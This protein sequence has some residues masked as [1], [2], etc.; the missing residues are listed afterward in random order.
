M[1]NF[2]ELM[3][4]RQ[5][6]G[7]S[8]WVEATFLGGVVLIVAFRRHQIVSLYMFRVSVI[9]FGLSIALPVLLLPLTH[10]VVG[11]S[12]SRSPP[13]LSDAAYMVIIYGSGPI[14]F[15][16]SVILCVLS[17]LPARS[18]YPAPPPSPSQPHPLD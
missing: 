10:A 18:R 11:G 13:R 14:L 4:V 5:L 16:I 1:Q 17:M 9:L 2:F 12:I 7:G 6:M 8:S 15:A 3:Q